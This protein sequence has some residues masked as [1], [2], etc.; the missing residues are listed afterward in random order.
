MPNQGNRA[1]KYGALQR[2]KGELYVPILLNGELVGELRRHTRLSGMKVWRQYHVNLP[3]PAAPT[4]TRLN[5]AKRDV[6]AAVALALKTK[7]EGM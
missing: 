7:P 2:R 3:N 5:D 1:V 4:W 6:R